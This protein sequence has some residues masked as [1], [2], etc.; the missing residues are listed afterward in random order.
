MN[1]VGMIYRF[2]VCGA[3]FLMSQTANANLAQ[4]YGLGS[5]I[6]SLGGAGVAWGYEGFAS[7]YNPAGLAQLRGPHADHEKK[8]FF[9][10]GVVFA[11]PHFLKIDSVVTQNQ[12]TSDIP[13]GQ[14]DAYGSVDVNYRNTFSQVFGISYR[15]FNQPTH[16]TVGLTAVTPFEPFAYFDTGQVYIPEYV[17]YRS[18]NQRPQ[19][20]LGVGGRLTDSFY[21]GLGVHIGFGLTSS[22]DVFVTNKANATST[23]SFSAS[24]KPKASPYFGILFFPESEFESQP[25]TLGAVFRFPLNY[26]NTITLNTN[27]AIS[28]NAA[29]PISFEA[30]SS[31]FYDPASFE[32]GGSFSVLSGFRL[33]PQLDIQFWRNFVP[34]ALN[35]FQETSTDSTFQIKNAGLPSYSYQ[36]LLVPRLGGEIQMN[37]KNFFRF[38]VAYR[39]SIFKDVPNGNGNYLDP[40]KLMTSLGWGFKFFEFLGWDLPSNLD[41]HFSYQYLFRQTIVKTSGNEAGISSDSKI[42]SPGYTAGGYLIG[43]GVSL[44]VAL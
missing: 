23:M 42:G 19:F 36:N 12:F 20:E 28:I 31:F 44:S 24:M 38:G 14:P 33:I 25:F 17:L 35:I 16:L 11:A 43:G 15:I 26:T 32:L 7:Y 18:R 2:V 8:I 40:P 29:V 37:Q 10:Y 4:D 3:L 1:H 5:R 13:T 39:E 6:S 9:N 30:N 34:P 41:I 22:S 27:T 21:V